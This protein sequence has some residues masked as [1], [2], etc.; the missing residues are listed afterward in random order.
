MSYHRSSLA[1]LTQGTFNYLQE[2]EF[3]A[4]D[5]FRRAGLDPEKRT[6][7]DYR[8]GINETRRL[9]RIAFKETGNACLVYDVVKYIE[10][11]MLHAVGHAWVSSQT[12]LS[13]LKRLERYH[14][15]L[16]T[17][18]EMKLEPLQGAWQLETK[19]LE[20]DQNPATDGVNA[21]VLEM[22]RR[23]YGND[24]VPLQV[25][26]IRLEPMDSRPL[27]AFFGCEVIYGCAENVLVFNSSDLNRKL[28]SA[29]PA[30]ASAMDDVIV[31]YLARFDSSDIANR[32]RQIVAAY[33]IHGEPDKQ[34][35]AD[36]LGMSP[37][38]LQRRLE[39]QDTSV[40]ELIDQ[41]RHQ[42]A[43]EYLT[44]DHLSVKEVAFSLGFNDASNFSRAFKRWEGKSPK[45][46]RKQA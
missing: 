24:L 36:E 25:Q 44:Q 19:V 32:T 12:L 26:L 7:P 37:R 14:R 40:K 27:E 46:Y 35:I 29:N 8:Y 6:D 31:D 2:H 33:L 34:M 10:P 15:V 42:L 9:W 38:T 43:L 17:Q 30:V 1:T 13:A 45:A 4:E 5:M 21:F 18:I 28:S 41:T 23:S 11:W 22:C 20:V 16:S 39:E 3:D